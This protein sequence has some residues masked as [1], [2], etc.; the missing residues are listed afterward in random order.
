MQVNVFVEKALFS[1]Y[2]YC[3]N[4]NT[5]GRFHRAENYSVKHGVWKSL[6]SNMMQ[7][8]SIEGV[9]WMKGA[10][11]LLLGF[12]ETSDKAACNVE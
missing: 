10:L 3:V 8:N 2:S 7:R 4:L 9:V 11:W 1:I 12:D 5:L 6:I